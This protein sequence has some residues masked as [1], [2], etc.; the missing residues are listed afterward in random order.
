[1]T[2][3]ELVLAAEDAEDLEIVS[4]RLQDAVAKVKDLVWLPKARR[5]VCIFNRFKWEEAEEKRAGGNLRVKSR[6]HFDDVLS[7][8]SQNL[9]RDA[10]DAIL[11]LLTIRF[12][13]NGADDPGGAVELVFPGGP[14]IRLE[15]EC[16][17]AELA[18]VSGDWAAR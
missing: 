8:K 11:S 13:P 4:A 12:R 17:D 3:K 16:I 18:D 1:M 2:S 7:A 9:R 14:V 5:F 10:P 6:L 15:V